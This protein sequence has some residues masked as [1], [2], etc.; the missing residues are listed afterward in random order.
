MPAFSTQAPMFAAV[1][2]STCFGQAAPEVARICEE[3]GEPC[4]PDC[5]ERFDDGR[6][7]KCTEESER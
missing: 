3:C 6:C 4:C 2:C 5:A 7:T 1:D